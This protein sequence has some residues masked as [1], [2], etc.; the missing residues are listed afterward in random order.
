MASKLVAAATMPASPQQQE[1][2]ATNDLA[3]RARALTADMD[4]TIREAAARDKQRS[5]TNPFAPVKAAIKVKVKA[6]RR[7]KGAEGGPSTVGEW[8]EKC[9]ALERE[10]TSLKEK[11]AA[12]RR[13]AKSTTKIVQAPTQTTKIAMKTRRPSSRGAVP[14]LPQ[15]GCDSLL[16]SICLPNTCR[17]T[18]AALLQVKGAEEPQEDVSLLHTEVRMVASQPT[19]A[20]CVIR[21]DDV[22]D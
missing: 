22:A 11:L 19:L 5:A 10:N 13:A 9:Q 3:S 4:R 2:V 12:L 18:G 21:G 1:P 20:G 7:F 14:I 15:A 6:G 17:L 8:K 16:V